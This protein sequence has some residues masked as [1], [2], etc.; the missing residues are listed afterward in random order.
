[1]KRKFENSSNN[2]LFNVD[3][4]Q[5][6]PSQSKQGNDAVFDIMDALTAPILTFSPSWADTIPKRLLELVP[7]ERMARILKKEEYATDVECV[8]YIYTRTLEAPMTSEW[9]DIFT[10][11]S[12]KVCQH[13]FNEN[14]WT[15]VKA[16]KE[17]SK[18]LTSKLNDLRRFIFTKR[19]EIVKQI[20]LQEKKDR[21]GSETFSNPATKP[22]ST[23]QSPQISF[24]F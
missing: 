18:W 24:N 5:K 15:E 21:K 7:L 16:P 19:R 8:I 12:C 1:M 4:T 2:L 6:P 14:H 20:I 10:H 22:Q 17:L 11:L 13:W 3:A 23:I 9:T